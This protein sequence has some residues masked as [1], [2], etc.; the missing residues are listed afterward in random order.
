MSQSSAAVAVS[1][2]EPVMLPVPPLPR[3]AGSE[4]SNNFN[5]LRLI[6]ALLVIVSHSPELAD[7][8]RS[9]ELF[10]RLFHTISFGEFA[11]DGF[12]LLSGYLIVQSWEAR[13]EVWAFSRKRIFR[14]Y[15]GYVVASLAC[16]FVVGPL[17]SEPSVYFSKFD[18]V[19]FLRSVALLDIPAIPP[20]FPGQPFPF[21]NGAMWT[22]RL[23]L[24]C[25]LGVLAA[26]LS[27]VLRR[28]QVWLGLTLVALVLAFLGRLGVSGG[29]LHV[30]LTLPLLRLSAFFLVGGACYLFRS[31]LPT[32]GWSA[33]GCLAVAGAG[34][35]SKSAVEFVLATFGGVALFWFGRRTI[36]GLSEF[37]RLPDV[38]YG[39]YLYAW[40]M[41]KLLLQ[42]WPHMSPWTLSL[43][44]GVLSLAIGALSWYSVER[45]FVRMKPSERTTRR[46]GAT[47]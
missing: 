42:R 3:A 25:Y 30:M 34:L 9:R 40:P 39:V 27:G 47:A 12:F 20:V 45:P 22:I 43:V 36:P 37:N 11:V 35:F 44:V 6:L 41:Q 21:V 46:R 13:P 38:S 28:P 31:F 17:A 29:I 2:V 8:N 4:R 24:I 33:L 1:D 16:A 10:T 23:E 19:A 26:G 7:G 18:M 32:R 14:I 5:L 15:P